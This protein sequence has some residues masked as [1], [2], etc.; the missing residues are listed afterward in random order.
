M[1]SVYQARDLVREQDVALKIVR[2]I[3]DGTTPAERIKAFETEIR[4]ASRLYHPRIVRIYDAGVT[5]EGQPYYS[6]EL[7]K[8]QP[9]TPMKQTPPSWEMLFD[10]VDQLL[11]G[12][13]FAHARG[14]IHRDV[15]PDNILLTPKSDGSFSVVLTDLG[16]AYL[17]E[18]WDG[19]ESVQKA[20][21]FGTPRYMAPEQLQGSSREIG[22]WTD[23]Y[24]LGGI[25]FEILSG[26]SPF[27]GTPIKMA[28]AKL[29]HDAPDLVIREGFE[30]P[31][32]IEEIVS[33]LLERDSWR[34][35]ELASDV[36]AALRAL[37]RGISLKGRPRPAPVA[38][39]IE[40]PK[41][42]STPRPSL[43]LFSSR[44]PSIIGRENAR[45]VLWQK[46]REVIET[47]ESRVVLIEGEAGVGK[48]RL[49]RWLSEILDQLGVMRTVH[50]REAE[51]EASHQT[52]F[53]GAIH[54]HLR[55]YRLKNEELFA[56]ISA[57]LRSHGEQDPNTRQHVARW[58]NPEQPQ[59]AEE[60]VGAPER[61]ALFCD[62][63]RRESW[64]G[65]VLLWIDD[66]AYAAP[67]EGLAF[68]ERFLLD[69]ELHEHVPCLIVA[70]C[71]KESLTER[72]R[73][74]PI[75]TRLQLRPEF[76][77][78]ELDRL[79][80]EESLKLVDHLLSLSPEVAQAVANRG[81]GNPLYTT[82]LLSHLVQDELLLEGEDGISRL[83]PE[84]D[85]RREMPPSI[86]ALF[87][88]QLDAVINGSIEPQATRLAIYAASFLGMEFSLEAHEDSLNALL[89]KGKSRTALKI[90]WEEGIFRRGVRPGRLRFDHHFLWETTH[91]LAEQSEHARG[92]HL[93][94]ARAIENR[95]QDAEDL[96]S[97]GKHREKGGDPIGAARSYFDAASRMIG[98]DLPRAQ[99]LYD[100]SAKLAAENPSIQSD[101]LNP[102]LALGRA[103][104]AEQQNNL[105]D[106]QDFFV[107]ALSLLRTSHNSDRPSHV[108]ALL[109]LGNLARRRGAFT[110]AKNHLDEAARAAAGDSGSEAKASLQLAQLARF[111]GDLD[112][113]TERYESARFL[114]RVSKD[115]HV[116]AEALSGL[117]YVLLE[118]NRADK[119]A[120][121]LDELQKLARELGN[122]VLEVKAKNLQGELARAQNNWEAAS[123]CYRE[124]LRLSRAANYPSGAAIC[125][126]N[127]AFIALLNNDPDG[128]MKH[129]QQAQSTIPSGHFWLRPI[130]ALYRAWA[131]AL[132]GDADSARARLE[133]SLALGLDRYRELDVAR[134]AEGLFDAAAHLKDPGLSREAYAI[135]R[136]QYTAL[137]HQEAAEKL[138]S[139]RRQPRPEPAP[140]PPP[141][142]DLDDSDNTDEHKPYEDPS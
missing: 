133:E 93:G 106:A 136:S 125:R 65:G 49:A 8:G 137:G 28:M 62:V 67:S 36:R 138:A 124:G 22:P 123:E 128:A 94:A 113:A 81:E 120:A 121:T 100:L 97:A 114:G 64:R 86:E 45:K 131:A 105:N 117:A 118:R 112:T 27:D 31:Q 96:F 40:A 63:L 54:R 18:R 70:T 59:S 115:R 101:S 37:P 35:F 135:A 72:P 83:K 32:G 111:Q 51:G 126:Y 90:A 56:R 2:F 73:L 74:P 98:F 14:V 140:E 116:E 60:M 141:E 11:D 95:S 102:L 39:P 25:L 119:V 80:P 68:I 7:I 77:E 89:P 24:A 110:E 88:T 13:A 21:V 78:I 29:S 76:T 108:R 26:Q 79:S 132:L 122:R 82:M 52:G 92:L 30:A 104:I 9:L 57:Y 23:L 69:R 1:G 61:D 139:R 75:R 103:E 42:H 15:K 44:E 87:R 58:L 33:R 48:S 109:G 130:G 41:E 19:T 46:A 107:T 43:S 20:E 71:R 127:L 53:L 84:V 99:E 34:R 16:L 6:M 3:A 66:I 134:A 55:T 129:L 38:L 91:T 17:R 5:Q 12:L 142:P 50:V 10:I 85:L 4:F 47:K